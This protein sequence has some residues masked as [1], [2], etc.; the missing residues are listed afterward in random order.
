MI[1]PIILSFKFF[2]LEIV[3]R[4]YG[5]LV[6]LGAVAG[7]L[8]AEREIRRRGENGDVIWDA[9]VWVLP[10]GILGARLWYVA[11]NILSGSTYYTEDPSFLKI[12]NTLDGGLHFFGGLLFGGITLLIYLNKNGYDF[13]LFLDAIA[14]AVFIGQALARPANFINQELY[15]QPTNLPWGIKIDPSQLYQTPTSMIGHSQQEVLEFIKVTR[16]HPTFAY[17]MILNILLALLLLWV[18]RQYKERIKPGAIF[19][20]WLVLAGLARAFIELFRP[21]QPKIGN[22]FVSYTMFVSFLMAIVGVVM[23]LIRNRKLAPALADSWEAQYQVKRVGKETRV[24]REK[25]VAKGEAVSAM[26][27]VAAP[28]INQ[29]VA[30]SAPLISAAAVPEKKKRAVK[31]KAKPA[32]KAKAKAPAKKVSGRKPLAGKKAPV[33]KKPAVKAKVTAK[34]VSGK[35]TP[36]A[37]KPVVKAKV[38]VKKPSNKKAS[39]K[40][41]SAK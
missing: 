30:E 9:M 34:K 22:S 4:W 27:A 1:D 15:G 37:K 13:W 20:G 31:V 14:P 3:L 21:D 5:V 35:K 7:A 24:R 40:S 17:E 26:E 36:A 8:I 32:V 38:T 10:F 18:S 12:I 19:S 11:S 33:A 41:K 16:F 23:L 6:M 28:E 2:N 29:A 39:A 25:A